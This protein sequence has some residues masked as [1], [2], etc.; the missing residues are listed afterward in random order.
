MPCLSSSGGGSL[1]PPDLRHFHYTALTV[2]NALVDDYRECHP[3]GIRP[4]VN[5]DRSD[6][7]LVLDLKNHQQ[8]GSSGVHVSL[9]RTLHHGSLH[10]RGYRDGS[11]IH[12]AA[13]HVILFIMFAPSWQLYERLINVIMW[14]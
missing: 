6:V 12:K 14:Q 4:D 11:T 5:L 13:H 3:K 1:F 10:K 9:Y 2:K 8:R 7:P